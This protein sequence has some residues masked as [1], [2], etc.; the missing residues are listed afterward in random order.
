MRHPEGEAVWSYY[1]VKSQKQHEF[2][3]GEDLLDLTMGDYDISN[4]TRPVIISIT[5]F[6][7]KVY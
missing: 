4:L 6:G 1:A 2:A 5:V 7:L 3:L